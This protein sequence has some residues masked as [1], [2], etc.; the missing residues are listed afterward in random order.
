VQEVAGFAKQ[1]KQP[2]VEPGFSP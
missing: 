1:A 2:S